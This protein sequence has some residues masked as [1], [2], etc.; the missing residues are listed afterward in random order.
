M[1]D[2][3]SAV[4]VS[5][6]CSLISTGLCAVIG[7]PL[8]LFLAVRRFPGSSAV[9][10][11]LQSLLAIPTVV[12]GLF[13]YT[14][15]RRNGYLGDFELLYS[16]GAIIVGQTVLAIPIMTIFTYSAVNAIDGCAVETAVTLGARKLGVLGTLFN[17][18]RL[19]IF[20]AIAATF[21][22]LIGEVG[23]SMMLGGN[24]LG[25]TRT[26][27]TAIALETSKG[28]FALAIKLGG[29]LLLVSLS[30]NLLLRFFQRGGVK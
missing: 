25:M 28:E 14:L 24:I 29:A 2:F 22:R 27:T 21:G 20:A 3:F 12:V 9:V 4:S 6:Y 8:G 30:V 23:V 18:A 16:L 15:I 19:G 7:I 10:A 17:E 11:V 5:L 1:G 13:V 26:M